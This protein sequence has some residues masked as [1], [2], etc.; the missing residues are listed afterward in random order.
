MQ[1]VRGLNMK[2]LVTPLF[3]LLVLVFFGLVA[4]VYGQGSCTPTSPGYPNCVSYT[5][6]R[7]IMTSVLTLLI[8][9]NPIV[10]LAYFSGLTAGATISQKRLIANRPSAVVV[11]LLL[12][13]AYVG[14]EILSA[15][16]I[17]L[18]YIMIAGG[19]FIL[20]FAIKDALG[21]SAI[22]ERVNQSPAEAAPQLSSADAER[23][24]IIPLAVPVLAGPGAIAA[25]MILNDLQYGFVADGIAILIDTAICWGTMRLSGS[26]LRLV[27]PSY[28]T[29]LGKIMDIL[30]GAVAVAFLIRGVT[31]ALGISFA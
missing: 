5:L 28:L 24:A 7:D 14:D 16:G 25:V 20:I 17:T 10:G 13:F 6:S 23:V 2:I 30:I 21:S 3:F 26:I 31:G 19:L 18:H 12:F 9:L 1:L 27:R 11:V 4:R 29:I 15:L 22:L 8:V